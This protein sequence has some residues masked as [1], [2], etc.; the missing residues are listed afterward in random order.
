MLTGCL[1]GQR[2]VSSYDTDYD[3]VEI[4]SLGGVNVS[5]KVNHHNVKAMKSLLNHISI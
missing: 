3:G 1:S 2:N 4:M 5:Y